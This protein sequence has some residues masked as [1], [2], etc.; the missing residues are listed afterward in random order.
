[1]LRVDFLCACR[2]IDRPLLVRGRK[3]HLRTY[4][5]CVGSLTAYVFDEILVLCAPDKYDA[6]LSQLSNHRSHLTN[7]CLQATVGDVNGADSNSAGPEALG[8]INLLSELPQ[9]GAM[10][11]LAP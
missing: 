3:F 8:L 7:T 4:V 2:Y 5:L 6:A 1:M 9:V 11:M 10:S